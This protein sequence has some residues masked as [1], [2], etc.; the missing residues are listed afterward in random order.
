MSQK[1]C[2]DFQCKSFSW[3]PLFPCCDFLS[4][5]H[6]LVLINFRMYFAFPYA[7]FKSC[8]Y[9]EFSDRKLSDNSLQEFNFFPNP[10]PCHRDQKTLE[11]SSSPDLETLKIPLFFF[12]KIFRFFQVWFRPYSGIIPEKAG[13]KRKIFQKKSIILSFRVRLW[14][15]WSLSSPF[16]SSCPLNPRPFPVNLLR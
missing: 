6:G 9:S 10:I 3:F 11:E 15:A 1:K 7:R 8:R 16:T 14:L 2:Y 4:L 12:R 5:L 13:K